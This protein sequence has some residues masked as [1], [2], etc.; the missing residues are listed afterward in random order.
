MNRIEK[1]AHLTFINNE[2]FLIIRNVLSDI[3]NQV[4]ILAARFNTLARLAA[5][6]ASAFS[7]VVWAQGLLVSDFFELFNH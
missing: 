2:R 6:F 4:V 1:A 3:A 7:V 5:I